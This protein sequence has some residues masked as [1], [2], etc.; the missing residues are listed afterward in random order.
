LLGIGKAGNRATSVIIIYI[1]RIAGIYPVDA[2]VEG[3]KNFG[4]L[5]GVQVEEAA[6][7]VGRGEAAECEVH[8]NTEVVGPAFEGLPEI[9]IA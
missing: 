2:F 3:C 6:P 7:N 5:R 4:N 8:N 9:R 1:A